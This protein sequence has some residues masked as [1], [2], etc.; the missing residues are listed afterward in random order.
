MT[1][2]RIDIEITDS[3]SP[4][5]SAKLRDIAEAALAADSAVNQLKRDIA[6]ID[7]SAVDRLAAASA[8][9]TNANARQTNAT[10]RLTTATSR[11]EV[12]AAKTAL[13][14]QRLATETA[15]TE[16][17]T[18]RAAAA[19]SRA[20]TAQ[21]QQELSAL[22][23]ATAQARANTAQNAANTGGRN[24]ARTVGNSDKMSRQYRASLVNLSYQLQ[25]IG[26]GFASGQRPF[27]IFA[28]QL[29]QIY[30][31]IQQMGGGLRT[32]VGLLGALI[33][34]L[35][36]VL[37]IV[38][39]IAAGFGLLT[40]EINKTS[41]VTVTFGD[42]FKAVFQVA[43]QSIKDL[44][45]PAIEAITPVW[46]TVLDGLY[47]G[48]KYIVN[49][50][51]NG[52]VGAWK[53]IT[54]LWTRF[55]DVMRDVFNTAVNAVLSAIEF[56]VNGAIKG[57]NM[58]IGLA[59]DAAR[60][61]GKD[62]GV[63][64][65]VGLLDLSGY[66]RDMT[67]AGAEVGDAFVNGLLGAL[68]PSKQ[69][70]YFG[71]FVSKVSVQAQKN[72]RERLAAEA[73]KNKKGKGGRTAKETT[74]EDIIRPL[75]QEIELLQKVGQERRN[76]QAIQ[77]AENQLKRKLTPDEKERLTNLQTELDTLRKQ[78]E[79]LTRIN[80]PLTEYMDSI[81]A[82]NKLFDDGRISKAAYNEQLART[83]LATD[84]RAADTAL[85]GGFQRDAQVEEAKIA[86][87]AIQRAYEQAY[88]AQLLS[89][90]QFDARMLELT[91][92]RIADERNALLAWNSQQLSST[93]DSFAT[94]ANTAETFVGKQSGIYQT[95]FA[96]SKAFAIADATVKMAQAIANASI[97]LPFPANLASMA[98]V[99]AQMASLLATINSTAL[100]DGGMVRGPGTSRSDSIP[101]RLSNGE[102]VINAAA[103][104]RN[105]PLLESIN[106][107]GKPRAYAKGGA[108]NDNVMRSTAAATEERRQQYGKAGAA[109]PANVEVYN[110]TD[111][112]Q[113]QTLALRAMT[114]AEGRTVVVNSVLKELEKRGVRVGGSGF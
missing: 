28:Q 58:V 52:F 55:P 31:I 83:Q 87:D 63:F 91:R 109:S 11:S 67:G 45:L 84:V 64:N 19:A 54:V 23:L 86:N 46:N 44:L 78:D 103:T 24:W 50:I 111:P 75:Q 82:L 25:D 18:E 3:V 66:K 56:M 88:Q 47:T 60:A 65:P 14:Q 89:K 33:V 90:Q 69:T 37:A 53:T 92:K 85:G 73:A 7:T 12:Q 10:A 105:R 113:I 41:A 8:R 35:L 15:R 112:K 98:A 49:A 104:K 79:I 106:N 70:D 17:A 81:A 4:N 13:A 30:G 80:E 95:L 93:A 43:G 20:A 59:N 16:A 26:V 38:G 97:S 6:K 102:F 99:G 39:G 74:F 100:A 76:L 108:V 110:V 68:D 40:R 57:L 107:G 27:T 77:Q 36:P 114:G 21:T 62:T 1:D 32:L 51:I 94:M 48:L 96:A 5:V 101:A 42:T 9:V 72:A 61:L 29:P 22:R 71:K 34:P 2:E